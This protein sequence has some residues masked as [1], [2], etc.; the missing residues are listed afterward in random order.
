ME[1]KKDYDLVEFS[2][3]SSRC[4]ILSSHDSLSEAIEAR[5]AIKDDYEPTSNSYVKVMANNPSD[6]CWIEY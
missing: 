1:T 3:G 4:R 2:R 5:E 6:D